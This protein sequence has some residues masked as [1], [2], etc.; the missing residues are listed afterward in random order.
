MRSQQPSM[1]MTK[2]AS[3]Q[4]CRG[5]TGIA[6][7]QP[8]RGMTEIASQQ[9]CRGTTEIASRFNGWEKNA[10]RMRA[11]GT[12]LAIYFYLW[13]KLCI[14]WQF[15]SKDQFA[16]ANYSHYSYFF[17]LKSHSCHPSVT[18]DAL[19][20]GCKRPVHRRSGTL[21]P[22]NKKKRQHFPA[23]FFAGSQVFVYLCSVQNQ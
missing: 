9:P 20:K 23:V 22:L 18:P 11:V 3:Q 16:P 19:E 17:Q 13:T 1:G 2:I 6:S 7:Q 14:L 5:M 10:K 4:P 12:R 15:V 21:S 8:C